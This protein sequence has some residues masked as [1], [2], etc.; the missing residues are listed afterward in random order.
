LSDAIDV[1]DRIV[2]AVTSPE[3]PATLDALLAAAAKDQPNETAL[4]RLVRQVLL[5][6]LEK[7]ALRK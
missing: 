1:T 6:M 2:R 5:S 7:R 3:G 4:E